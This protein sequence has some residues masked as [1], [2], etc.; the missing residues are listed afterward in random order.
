MTSLKR[1]E[2][3]GKRR[4]LFDPLGE[5]KDWF[6]RDECTQCGQ[7]RGIVSIREVCR[8]CA[9]K[10]QL[11]DAALSDLIA[12]ARRWLAETS[13]GMHINTAKGR[14]ETRRAVERLQEIIDAR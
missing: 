9:R 13:P 4:R 12:G 7:E 8:D 2:S 11:F 1:D 14:H 5:D 6:D 10:D 3:S